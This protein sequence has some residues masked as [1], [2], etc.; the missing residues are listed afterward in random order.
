M[1][2]SEADK[3]AGLE[4]LEIVEFLCGADT[5]YGLWYG[6][7]FDDH[8]GPPPEAEAEAGRKLAGRYWWRTILRKRFDALRAAQQETRKDAGVGEPC[9]GCGGTG[10]MAINPC[11]MPRGFMAFVGGG[12]R[13]EDGVQ[14]I[15]CPLCR[16]YR[17]PGSPP[18]AT[19]QP[20]AWEIR[21]T[22]QPENRHAT[23]DPEAA[24]QERRIGSSVIPLYATPPSSGDA[25]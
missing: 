6:D 4:A 25:P 17:A 16:P 15:V 21:T 10:K 9:E 23:F 7:V 19:V 14:R 24:E 20:V 3:D 22:T 11:K 8:A 2:T 1:S 18:A 13:D 5:L 12:L